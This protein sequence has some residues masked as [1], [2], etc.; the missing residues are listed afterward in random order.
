MSIAVSASNASALLHHRRTVGDGQTMLEDAKTGLC[1]P[2]LPLCAHP[3]SCPIGA[4]P[5]ARCAADLIRVAPIT[6]IS[7]GLD[8]NPHSAM[9]PLAS[10][11]T[12]RGFLPRGLSDAYRRPQ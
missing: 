12:A 5:V 4:I 10:C 11:Q 1:S 6:R 3:L 9:L 2:E 7:N 8:S